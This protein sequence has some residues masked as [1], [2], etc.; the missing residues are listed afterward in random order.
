MASAH[1]LVVLVALDFVKTSL[2]GDLASLAGLGRRSRAALGR[3]L[4]SILV[5]VVI[6]GAVFLL[7]VFEFRGLDF[8]VVGFFDAFLIVDFFRLRG[9]ALLGLGL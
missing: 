5:L 3:S 6:V 2:L 8:V 7:I 4:L 9:L 1:L